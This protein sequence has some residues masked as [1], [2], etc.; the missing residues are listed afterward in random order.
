[1][2]NKGQWSTI[3]INTF[4]IKDLKDYL[5]LRKDS[6]NATTTET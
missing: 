3:Q 4:L 5:N 2:V 1:M 6:Q